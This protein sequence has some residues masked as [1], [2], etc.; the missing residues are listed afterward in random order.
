[1]PSAHT[2]IA[3]TGRVRRMKAATPE[4]DATSAV[5]HAGPT[6]PSVV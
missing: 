4:L 5:S 6:R 2:T 3:A 1:M